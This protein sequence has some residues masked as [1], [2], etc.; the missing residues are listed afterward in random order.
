MGMHVVLTGN[1]VDGFG[2]LGPFATAD[3]A[4]EWADEA[5]DRD[6]DWWVTPLNAPLLRGESAN[7]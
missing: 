1:P 6:V 2:V 5:L 3:E 7:E 4:T